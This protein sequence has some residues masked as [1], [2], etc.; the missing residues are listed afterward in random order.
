MYISSNTKVRLAAAAAMITMLAATPMAQAK[1]LQFVSGSNCALMIA[2][3]QRHIKGWPTPDPQ[4]DYS[5][6][7]ATRINPVINNRLAVQP[8][9]GQ[10]FKVPESKSKGTLLP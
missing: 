1:C 4:P 2:K 5:R 6:Q 7:I 8:N 9:S 3:E 10:I